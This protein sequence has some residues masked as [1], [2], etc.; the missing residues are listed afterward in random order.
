MLFVKLAEWT[1]FEQC[2][3][4]EKDWRNYVGKRSD[5]FVLRRKGASLARGKHVSI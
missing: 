1:A 5:L 4:L 2:F 3:I